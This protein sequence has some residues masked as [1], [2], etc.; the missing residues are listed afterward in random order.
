MEEEMNREDEERKNGRISNGNF[1]KKRRGW[2][3]RR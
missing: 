3:E 2:E 1:G